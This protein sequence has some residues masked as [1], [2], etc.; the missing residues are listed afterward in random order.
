MTI[1]LQTIGKLKT[2]SKKVETLEEVSNKHGHYEDIVYNPERDAE[3]NEAFESLSVYF[4]KYGSHPKKPSYYDCD[5]RVQ[6]KSLSLDKSEPLSESGENSLSPQKT[7]NTSDSNSN[8]TVDGFL[9]PSP[10]PEQ[11]KSLAESSW[12]VIDLETTALTYYSEPVK[13]TQ[14]KIEQGSNSKP[15]PRIV[16]AFWL[17]SGKVNHF[18]WDLD[19]LD[20]ETKLSVARSCLTKTFIGHNAAFDLNWLRKLEADGQDENLA[21]G[22]SYDYLSPDNVIDT[23]LFA[24]LWVP[25]RAVNF[26]QRFYD[27]PGWDLDGLCRQFLNKKLDKTYQKP[28]NWVLP[29]PLSAGHYSYA[30]S[31]TEELYRLIG[32][33]LARVVPGYTFNYGEDFFPTFNEWLNSLD[34]PHLSKLAHMYLDYPVQLSNMH[35][36][37]MPV[38]QK[39]IDDYVESAVNLSKEKTEK[40]IALE[41][42]LEPFRA[43]L[44]D[45]GQGVTEDLKETLASAFESR[46]VTVKR[47]PKS[48][49]PQVGEKSLRGAGATQ[50]EKSKELFS[51][52][53]QLNKAQKN[54][55]MALKV[56]EFASR[57]ISGRVHSLFSPTTAT[58]RLSSSEP[59]AQQFPGDV[60]FRA[61]VTSRPENLKFDPETNEENTP[62]RIVACD[63]SALDVRV[64]A[65]LAIREQEN[66]FLA[67]KSGDLASGFTAEINEQLRILMQ[68]FSPLAIQLGSADNPDWYS[69]YAQYQDVLPSV[70][71]SLSEKD[72]CYHNAKRDGNWSGYRQAK[73]RHTCNEFLHVFFEVYL[74]AEEKGLP[75]KQG[76]RTYG[77]LRE[78]FLLGV[79]IHTYTAL[80]MDGVDVA[81]ELEGKSQDDVAELMEHYKTLLGGK[82]KVGKVSNLSLMYGMTVPS[83]IDYAS[84]AWDMHL[85][86]EEGKKI[87]DSWYG[88]YLEIKL[89]SLATE[90]RGVQ[91]LDTAGRPVRLRYGEDK[92]KTVTAFYTH[93]LTQRP[94]LGLGLNS[95]LNYQDQGTGADILVMTMHILAEKYPEVEKSIIN[96]VH[97][98]LVLECLPEHEKEYTL[99]LQEAM[100]EAG[101]ELLREYHVPMK[102]DFVGGTVWIKD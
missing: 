99:K 51:E 70:S 9:W 33:L 41:P 15:R 19:T 76:I 102:S 12:K 37:G 68:P 61:L 63:F 50:T 43:R 26:T 13:L 64:A 69:A 66:L 10:T 86:F 1:L 92:G 52:L 98:E 94:I 28:S 79:D 77:A 82:R 45:M 84:S 42:S 4:N 73:N 59:N 16:S 78:A 97:D 81:K 35:L 38:N 20:H 87:S 25:E 89:W 90:M 23:I 93:T 5:T 32:T 62:T 2:S 72:R 65:G 30:A 101:D 56:K 22:E 49:S 27:K 31:D 24:R 17:D 60:L 48:N 55:S 14:A 39:A 8:S 80:K 44:A 54:A 85:S 11:L 6:E 58:S 53:V 75:G 71:D 46:G 18:A 96:Q 91:V 29:A 3:I 47:T 88:I 21:P 74:L 57:S 7:D 36:K 34:T 100:N 67:F 40:L 95:G 83:F